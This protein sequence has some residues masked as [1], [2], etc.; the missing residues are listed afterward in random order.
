MNTASKSTMLVITIVTTLLAAAHSASA[1]VI[2]VPADQPTIQAGINAAATGDEVV[3]APGTYAECINFNGMAITLR[4]TDPTDPAIVEATILDGNHNGPMVTCTSGEGV[5]TVLSGFLITE[6]EITGGGGGMRI[7]GSNPTVSHCTFRF[8]LA[9]GDGGGMY[10]QNGSPMLTDCTFDRNFATSSGGGIYLEDSDAIATNCA[11]EGNQAVSGGGMFNLDGS[12]AL[13]DCQFK[14]N[15]VFGSGAGGLETSVFFGDPPVLTNCGFCF[16]TPTAVVGPF[17]NVGDTT[18][19][20]FCA[21][22]PTGACCL[23]AGGCITATAPDCVAAGGLYSGDDETCAVAA[24]PPPPPDP[25]PGDMNGDGVLDGED[26]AFIVAA[27][28]D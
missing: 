5:D 24:C 11:F 13:S 21:A 18:S 12:P 3:V 7:V 1:A 4:S 8:N 20:A 19:V 10:I 6:G 9:I 27:L 26:I 15:T 16:N 2:N 17:T 22:E 25:V 23:P 28:L 14:G